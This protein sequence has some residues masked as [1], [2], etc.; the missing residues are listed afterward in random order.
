MT[1]TLRKIAVS[2][3][4]LHSN[5]ALNLASR[6]CQRKLSSPTYPSSSPGTVTRL[7]SQSPLL[8]LSFPFFKGKNDGEQDEGIG[9]DSQPPQKNPLPLPDATTVS[10][11][12]LIRN[13]ASVT[14]EDAGSLLALALQQVRTKFTAGEN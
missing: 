14:G 3:V 12:H 6:I 13:S 7:I 5:A 11:H 8:L 2:I 1:L 4:T 10:L 9:G